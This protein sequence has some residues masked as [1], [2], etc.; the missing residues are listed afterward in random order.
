ML[1][2]NTISKIPVLFVTGNAN[3]LKEI[4]E[5][6]SDVLEVSQLDIDLPEY[7][8]TPEEVALEK[9]K[10]AWAQVKKP[11]LTEDTSLCFNAYGGLPGAYIKWFL[12]NLKVEGLFKMANAFEDRSA[13]AQTI[14]SYVYSDT[15]P[16]IQF[17]GQTHGTI[18]EPRGGKGFVGGW[19]PCFEPSD[20]AKTYAEMESNEK[21]LISHRGKAVAKMMEY[22][23]SLESPVEKKLK[24]D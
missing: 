16:P 17:L 3:K 11:L 10:T 19:D 7:Q 6:T 15:E 1:A 18:V 9:A 22:F 2:K 21:N 13:Y 12:Q 23:R 24:E 8:G 5:I 14:I 4:R 20:T